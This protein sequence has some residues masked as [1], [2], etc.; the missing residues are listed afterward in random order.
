VKTDG[1]KLYFSLTQRLERAGAF[2]FAFRMFPKNSDLPH[3]MDFCY[4]RWI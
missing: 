2:K 3:R 1:S 4:V